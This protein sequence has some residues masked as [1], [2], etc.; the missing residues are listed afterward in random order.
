MKG[1]PHTQ[2]YNGITTVEKLNFFNTLILMI[3][4]LDTEVF[5]IVVRGKVHPRTGHESPYSL[6]NLSAR[7]DW[8]VK[9]KPR[10]LYLLE[11]DLIPSV[12]EA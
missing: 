10:P 6:F 3:F 1:F 9:T 11:K 7:L 4:Q 12:Q 2:T 8:L 5:K